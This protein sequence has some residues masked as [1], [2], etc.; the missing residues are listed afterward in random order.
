MTFSIAA[1]D[2]ASGMFGVAVSSSSPA[3]A[4][5]CAHVRA[6][7]GAVCSQNITDPRLGTALLDRLESGQFA[8]EAIAQVVD[9]EPLISFRQLSA[10]GRWGAP[11]AYSGSGVLGTHAVAHGM[12]CICCGNLLSSLRVPQAMVDAFSSESD[13]P[14]PARLIAAMQAAIA[15]GGEEGPVH[16]VG[17]LVVRDVPWPIVDLRVDWSDDPIGDLAALWELW[18]PQME[19]YVTRA[20]N[21][22]GAPSYGVPGD[23]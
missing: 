18:E 10:I 23:E 17:L 2:T 9:A 22:G 21:P 13:L 19:A 20:L 5:R 8:E 15:A 11:S 4:A 16:S 3:V 1:R 7:V 6:G 12:D 14:F